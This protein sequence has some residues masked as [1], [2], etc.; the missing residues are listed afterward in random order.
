M[1]INEVLGIL[2]MS[3]QIKKRTYDLSGGQQQRV[4]IARAMAK[5]PR[6][7]IGDEP[8]GALDS[9]TRKEVFK[10]FQD[11][12][13]KLGTTIIIVTHNEETAK[14]AN[15]VI[16]VVDGRIDEIIVNKNPMKASQLK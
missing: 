10:F 9:K 7:L 12:N 6:I 14:L 16:K 1:E 3:N 15:K 11:I 2:G 8:T 13:N 5:S 4:S